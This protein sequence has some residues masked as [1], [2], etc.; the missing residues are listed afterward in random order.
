MFNI[1]ALIANGIFLSE[2]RKT[3][4]LAVLKNFGRINAQK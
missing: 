3:Y 2:I 4:L 1:L